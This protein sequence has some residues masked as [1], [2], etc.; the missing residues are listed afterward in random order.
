MYKKKMKE[1]TIYELL[2]E[3][4]EEI[5]NSSQFS[6][7]CQKIGLLSPLYLNNEELKELF[8]L[9]DINSNNVVT[10][11]EF[12]NFLKKYDMQNILSTIKN[13]MLRKTKN[14]FINSLEAEKFVILSSESKINIINLTFF[15]FNFFFIN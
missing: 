3:K 7:G 12:L 10:L 15:N 6:S 4:K 13:E 2:D 5:L 8:K 11:D 14:N 9:M 1:K